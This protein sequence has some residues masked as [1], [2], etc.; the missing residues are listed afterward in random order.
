MSV[1]SFFSSSSEGEANADQILSA[2]EKIILIF[3]LAVIIIM[4]VLGNLLV[5]VAVCKDRQLR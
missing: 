3:F 5:M 1:L 4:T 2:T